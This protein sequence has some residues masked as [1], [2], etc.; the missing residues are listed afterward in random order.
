[1][2]RFLADEN[3]PLASVAVL[4]DHGHDVAAVAE[5]TPG[6]KDAAILARAARERRVLITFDRDY[7]ELIFRRALAIPAGV[8]Y[9]RF[10]P[11]SPEQPGRF[12]L[13]LLDVADLEIE[14]RF[15]VATRSE[16]RQRPLPLA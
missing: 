13:R 6:E 8:V 1:M 5:E 16:V 9:L 12:M 2:T 7:G 14:G 3:F 15:T 11:S 4:R 10:S